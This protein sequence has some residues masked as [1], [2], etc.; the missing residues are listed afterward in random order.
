MLA[1]SLPALALSVSCAIA[2]SASDYFRKAASS[3]CTAPLVL[4]Y[5]VSG[6]MPILALWLWTSGDFNI[7]AA[8]VAPGVAAA[9]I[10]LAA[11]LLLIAAVRQS[12]LSLMIPLLGAIPAVTAIFTGLIIG[13]WPSLLQTAG[14]GLVTIGLTTLYVPADEKF[15]FGTLWKSIQRERGTRPMAGVVILWS[16]APPLDKICV[17]LSSVGAHGLIQL[18]L[19]GAATGLWILMVGG[20]R[21]FVVPVTTRRPLIGAAISAGL[22]YGLQLA[23]Y[24]IAL[25]AIVELFKRAIGMVGSLILGRMMFGEQMTSPKILGIA[26]MAIGLP[27]II[28]S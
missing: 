3:S 12:P 26:I 6:Q 5:M 22:A 20:R 25:V 2:F 4:F 10:G 28:L 8:Y 9:L 17:G 21:A 24:Q 19:I 18:A 1:L 27:F 15:G 16:L 11:N 14:I 7:S 23:A 13:E